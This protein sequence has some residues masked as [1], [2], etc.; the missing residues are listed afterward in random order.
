LEG[1]ARRKGGEEGG[2]EKLSLS[3]QP[4]AN[5]EGRKRFDLVLFFV[6]LVE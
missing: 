4:V 3:R 2:K 5:G 1:E 6:R